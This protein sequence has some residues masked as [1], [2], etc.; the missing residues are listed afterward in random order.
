MQGGLNHRRIEP[1]LIKQFESS[2]SS[3]CVVKLFEFY[4][5][6]IP[7]VGP[8]YRK[9]LPGNTVNKFS[10]QVVGMH[11]LSKYMKTM[12]EEAKIDLSDRNIRNHSGKVTL[13]TNMY[14]QGLDEQAIMSRSG[15]RSTAVRDY[16]RPSTDLLLSVSDSLQ[17]PSENAAFLKKIKTET[18]SPSSSNAATLEINVPECIETVIINKNGK[19]VSVA[20]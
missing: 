19:K 6:C 20:L 5:R 1:K 17:S 16:K 7:P 3:R 8:F 9:P 11:I 14:A 18:A 12:F 10:S 2:D 15:H 4:L 13:C